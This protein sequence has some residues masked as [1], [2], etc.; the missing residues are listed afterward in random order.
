MLKTPF[1]PKQPYPR[2]SL[3]PMTCKTCLILLPWT[4]FRRVG[5]PIAH[6]SRPGDWRLD[7]ECQLCRRKASNR[8]AYLQR[9][10]RISTTT[11]SPTNTDTSSRT[12][13]AEG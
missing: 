9:R 12:D 11:P 13:Q 3:T 2:Q 7:D 6:E 1:P 10:G 8:L 5:R 4:L